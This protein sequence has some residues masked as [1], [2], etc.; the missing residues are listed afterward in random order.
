MLLLLLLLLLL[1]HHAHV[2]PYAL[3]LVVLLLGRSYPHPWNHLLVIRNV[4]LLTVQVS[5]I[6]SGVG[7]VRLILLMS[8][9]LLLLL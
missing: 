6:I 5:L 3:M 4:R 2:V 1:V 8:S 7:Y 9:L